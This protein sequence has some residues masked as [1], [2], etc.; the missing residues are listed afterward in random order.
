MDISYKDTEKAL[1]RLESEIK[2]LY[3]KAYSV[4]RKDMAETMAKMQLSGNFQ[5]RIDLA[6]KYDRLNAMSERCSKAIQ[7]AGKRAV[8]IINDSMGGV[9]AENY[10]FVANKFSIPPL[11][12]RISEKIVKSEINPFTKIA[13]IKLKNIDNIISKFETE[14]LSGFANGESIQKIT[15]RIKNVLEI[16]TKDAQRIART[17]VIRT[18]NQA[19]FDVGEEGKRLGFTIWKRWVATNDSRV[20]DDHAKMDGVEVPQDEPFVLPDG[21]K[22]M[23]PGDVSLGADPSQTI[24]CRCT[25][26]EFIKE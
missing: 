23:F 3:Q 20:R 24:S 8:K 4:I 26:I 2:A 9:Y 11:S 5:E 10:N 14:L 17:E 21:S 12:K 16:N 6:S 13:E 19:K 1:K 18:E 15:R 22:V 25:V 7:D